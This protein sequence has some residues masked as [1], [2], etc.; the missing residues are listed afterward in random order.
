MTDYLFETENLTYSYSTRQPR[1]SLDSVNIR[2][3]RGVRTAILGANGAGKSTLFYHF[4][5]IFKPVSGTVKY[6]G[7]PLD[8]SRNALSELRNDISVVVQNPDEQIFSA[9]VEEDIAFG[10]MSAGIDKEETERRIQD[11]LFKVGMEEYRSRPTI[12]LS[13]GQRK[14]VAFAGALAINPKVL[15]LDEPTAGLDPQMSQEVIELVEQLCVSGTTVIISTHDVDLAYAWADE[16]HVLREG[17]LIYSGE[18]ESFFADY[19]A[20]ASAGLVLPHTF[21]INNSVQGICGGRAEPYPRT[22]SQ[23]LCKMLPEGSRAGKIRMI[24]VTDSVPDS[25]DEGISSGIYG[26]VTRRL[27]KLAGREPDFHFNAIEYCLM[28]AI[29]G[30]DS[31]LYFDAPL[32]DRILEIIGRMEAFGRKIEVVM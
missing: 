1:P 8:Y 26:S 7:K 25:G 23:I 27:F 30:K 5:G 11:S 28:E 29:G 20:V 2:I 32:K 24:P 10:P 3:R 31:V 17:N 4:N 12:Q 21:S 19:S 16:I 13:Y 18:P 14:R 22:N 15:V 6:A 9:T